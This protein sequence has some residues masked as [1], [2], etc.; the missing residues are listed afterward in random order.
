MG[1]FQGPPKE[2]KKSGR[3]QGPPINMPT[4]DGPMEPVPST[5][6][7]GPEAVDRV[8]L[9]KVPDVAHTNQTLKDFNDLPE[10]KKALQAADDIVRLFSTG[11]TYGLTDTA[12]GDETRRLTDEAR[13][14]AGIPGAGAELIGGVV[15]PAT[16]LIGAGFKAVTPTAK[17]I[18]QTLGRL[19]ATSGEGA[20]IS[21]AG[22][23]ASGRPEDIVYDATVG[24]VL[25]HAIKG[26]SKGF[27]EPTKRITAWLAN[28]SHR[29]YSNAFRAGHTGNPD[30]TDAF[31]EG[32]SKQPKIA[33]GKGTAEAYKSGKALTRLSPSQRAVMTA[34]NSVTPSGAGAIFYNPLAAG[35]PAL[36][37]A[38]GSPRI[39]GEIAH[40]AGTVMG[41]LDMLTTRAALSAL[42]YQ[43]TKRMDR[44]K[45]N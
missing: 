33:T 1:R 19:L 16:R 25:P 45:K 31:R 4:E 2:S 10:Y 11:A 41:G 6:F 37:L 8:D 36:L 13:T 24:A 5:R 29:D 38:A 27:S 12:G 35:I 44:R 43:Q 14:R 18:W 15:S 21:G 22:A 40:A 30:V 20:T 32:I 28:K 3:F 17:G 34:I 23:L 7:Q 9:S 26:V 39:G 42:T